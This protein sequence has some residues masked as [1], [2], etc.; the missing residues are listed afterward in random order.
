MLVCL[1]PL[2]HSKNQRECC[3]FMFEK[4]VETPP[5]QKINSA[6]HVSLSTCNYI[7][8]VLK[9]NSWYHY[10][11][12]FLLSKFVNGVLSS[13]KMKCIHYLYWIYTVRSELETHCLFDKGLMKSDIMSDCISCAKLMFK[14][15]KKFCKM[16]LFLV[17]QS[18]TFISFSKE[19]FNFF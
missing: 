8:S 2:L 5:P 7:S 3:V 1:E 17:T 4:P 18:I 12:T 9:K 13:D 14:N 15:V 10:F 19:C 16:I 6:F 11:G